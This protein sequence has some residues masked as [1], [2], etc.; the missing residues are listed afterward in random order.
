MEPNQNEPK[1]IS[2]G[3]LTTLIVVILAAAGFFGWNYLQKQKVVTPV[4]APITTTEI[5]PSIMPSTAPTTTADI[6]TADWKTY[7][8]DKNGFSFKYPS[9]WTK[10]EDNVQ[11]SATDVV[12]DKGKDNPLTVIVYYGSN[13]GHG[14]AT[15]FSE[16]RNAQRTYTAG[17]AD[18]FIFPNGN[19]YGQ[20][21][22]YIT[23]RFIENGVVY[24]FEFN[25]GTIITSQD[26]QILNSLQFT[27]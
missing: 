19:G 27:P 20:T 14:G 7:T 23:E 24:A 26:T 8:N 2:P 25:G 3:L 15:Y 13:D 12:F 4:V 22:P 17:V 5:T 16:N 10:G 6:S 9:D 18:E 1:T 11:S 21:I